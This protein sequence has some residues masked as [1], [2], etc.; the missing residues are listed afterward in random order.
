MNFKAKGGVFSKSYLFNKTTVKDVT[1][2]NWWRNI[3]PRHQ[4]ISKEDMD[5]ICALQTAVGSSASVERVFSCFGMVHSKLRNRL[6]VVK[7]SKLVFLY[8]M[9]NMSLKNSWDL[10]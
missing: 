9:F 6:G 7:A 3:D 8:K 4:V 2:I 10:E 5:L 1:P